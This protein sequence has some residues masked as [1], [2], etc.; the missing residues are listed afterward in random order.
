VRLRPVR[1]V[2]RRP[3]RDALAP[4]PAQGALAPHRAHPA[5]VGRRRGAGRVTRRGRPWIALAAAAALAALLAGPARADGG[6]SSF[7]AANQSYLEG[8]FDDA[9]RQYESLVTAGVVHED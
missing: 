6:G 2:R 4:A 5:P 8:R 1:P 7:G 3:G 9:I